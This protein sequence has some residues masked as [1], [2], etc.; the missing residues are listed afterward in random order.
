MKTNKILGYY[1]FSKKKIYKFIKP[2]GFPT[3]SD[4]DEDGTTV[5]YYIVAGILGF[6]VMSIIIWLLGG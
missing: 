5:I 4:P 2:T 1:G 3:A 6:G